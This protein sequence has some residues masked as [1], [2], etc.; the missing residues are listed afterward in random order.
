MTS[1]WWS[2][3]WRARP[4][5]W[6]TGAA[7]P[8]RCMTRANTTLWWHPVNRS[9]LVCSR[10]RCRQS[11][12]RRAHG[13]AGRFR[14]RPVTPTLRREYSTSTELSSSTGS[15]SARR[16]P[17]S[18]ASRASIRRPI[19]S[20]RWDAAVPIR[21]PLQS[22]PPF[23]PTAAI[24]IP[25]WMASIRPTRGWFRRHGDSTRLLSRTCWN[26]P[27]R[28]PRFCRFAR[29]NSAWCTTCQSSFVPASTSPRTSTRMVPRRA[30]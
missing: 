15:G 2:R 13:R 28:A 24:S 21:R 18:R 7:R 12:S 6:S 9:P 22:P 25:T 26:W 14:S 30:R 29:W 1:R 11:A 20:P 23:M 8:H 16:S 17:S 27:P 5:N 3:P 19:E 10:S 4:T